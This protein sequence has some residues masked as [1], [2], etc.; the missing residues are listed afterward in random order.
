MSKNQAPNNSH[1]L[2]TE[3]IEKCINSELWVLLKG[4]MEIVGILRGMD[5]FLNLIIDDATEIVTTPAGRTFKKIEQILLNNSQ[6]VLL[7]PGS[8]PDYLPSE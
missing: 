7:V 8:R 3:V 2:P 5:M 6:I 4:N 1:F